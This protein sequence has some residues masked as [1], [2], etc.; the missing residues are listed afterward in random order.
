LGKANLITGVYD[1]LVAEDGV[2]MAPAIPPL[3]DALG[4]I[5]IE[6]PGYRLDVAVA[7]TAPKAAKAIG[8]DIVFA[9]ANISYSELVIILKK[10]ANEH[11]VFVGAVD[12]TTPSSPAVPDLNFN[13]SSFDVPVTIINS[14]TVPIS[15]FEVRLAGT[16]DVIDRVASFDI[17]SK[18]SE[19]TYLPGPNQKTEIVDNTAEILGKIVVKYSEHV[20]AE[21]TISAEDEISAPVA[22]P[23][24]TVIGNGSVEYG[25]EPGDHSVNYLENVINAAWYIIDAPDSDNPT[26]TTYYYTTLANALGKADEIHIT[27]DLVILEDITL[28]VADKDQAITIDSGAS[29]TVGDDDHSPVVTVLATTDIYN[30]NGPGVGYDVNN[31][32]IIFDKA[33]AEDSAFAAPTADVKLITDTKVIYT[34]VATALKL[35]TS[36]QEIKLLRE[37]WIVNEAT[38]PAGVTLND[39]GN[40]LNISAG[41]SLNVNGTYTSTGDVPLAAAAAPVKAKGIIGNIIVQSGGKVTFDANTYGFSGVIDIRAGGSVS[42]GTLDTVGGVT[43]VTNNLD[44]AK[45]GTIIN[46]GALVLGSSVKDASVALNIL[47]LTD[48]ASLTVDDSSVLIVLKDVTIGAP[49][50]LLSKLA[51]SVTVTGEITLG[52]DARATVYGDSTFSTSN[53]AGADT[54]TTLFK[55]GNGKYGG[56]TY[57]TQY[58]NDGTTVPIKYLYAEELKDFRLLGWYEDQTFI[59]PL[60]PNA[61][62]NIADATY[63]GNFTPKQYEVTLNY[64][65]GVEWTLNGVGQSTSVKTLI[66]YGDSIR[67]KA[68]VLPGFTGTPALTAN[69]FTYTADSAYEVTGTVDFKVTGVSTAAADTAV[70]NSLTLIEI[71]LIIIVI[72]IAIIMIVVAIKLLRS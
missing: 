39:D 69:G 56:K 41:A 35:A 48:S 63:Y 70:D 59:D 57:A 13:A 51:N 20:A 18:I 68:F 8:S 49:P 30:D 55:V 10:G 15:D 31:G 45:S 33:K 27:G 65:E 7:V 32:Q 28:G 42:F 54:L 72:I 29:L 71:L 43:T 36:G 5:S 46:A 34:D 12:T 53:I 9:G 52:P 67:V 3:T 14:K 24:A 58:A 6:K 22:I 37:S 61:P 38:I 21:L 47:S 66:N 50:T 4:T 64:D 26:S 16:V 40:P 19:Y 25:V 2:L 1:D 17:K 11:L 23:G 60:H 44:P 62:A